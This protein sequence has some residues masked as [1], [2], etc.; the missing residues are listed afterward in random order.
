M[1]TRL[2]SHAV[3][4]PEGEAPEWV[5]LLPAGEFMGRDGRGPFRADFDAVLSAFAE[6]AKPLGGDYDHQRLEASKKLGKVPASGWI[7]ELEQRE[8]GIWGR[9]QWT[10]AAA[11]AVEAR[12]FRYLSPVWPESKD[13]VVRSL[14]AWAITNE[15]NLRLVALNSVDLSTHSDES[16]V[17]ELFERLRDLLGLPAPATPEAMSAELDRLKARMAEVPAATV[18]ALGMTANARLP[19]LV[20]AMASYTPPVLETGTVDP[21]QFVPMAHH[22]QTVERL[23]ALE[24]AEAERTVGAMIAGR[25]LAPAQKDWALEYH[26]RDPEGFA[27]FAASA[28]EILAAHAQLGTPPGAEDDEDAAARRIAGVG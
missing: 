17:D 22:Q 20:Q 3:L 14:F 19:E 27:A 11:L 23:K 9:V 8:D 5:H 15:P 26:S 2:S 18:S 7:D 28:P 13:G 16:T 10:P 25:K 4:L 12:E 6:D 1:A 24:A 21:T